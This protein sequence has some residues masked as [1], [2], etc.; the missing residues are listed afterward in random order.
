MCFPLLF[1]ILLLCYAIIFVA[2]LVTDS[3]A[4]NAIRKQRKSA[5]G[6]YTGRLKKLCPALLLLLILNY[7]LL[8]LLSAAYVHSNTAQIMLGQSLKVFFFLVISPQNLPLTALTI[9]TL[10]LSRSIRQSGNDR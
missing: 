5:L 3:I 4:L 10:L 6:Q 7:L 2:L 9:G 8:L 1:K